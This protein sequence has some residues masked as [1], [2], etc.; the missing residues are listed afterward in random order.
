MARSNGVCHHVWWFVLDS[1]APHGGRRKLTLKSCPMTSIL[2]TQEAEAGES[3]QVWSHVGLYNR[4][5]IKKKIKM[6]FPAVETSPL[7]VESYGLGTALMWHCQLWA[8]TWSNCDAGEG[9]GTGLHK[10]IRW[11]L[12]STTS[13]W[14]RRGDQRRHQH[15]ALSLAMWGPVLT[16]CLS[17]LS[18][19]PWTWAVS[20]NKPLFL[21]NYPASGSSP[22][23]VD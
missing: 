2:S 19:E 20:Q 10:V 17:D 12:R 16:W 18:L 6:E 9:G 21:L 8:D 23:L 14:G 5:L 11:P 1:W 3:L 13:A 15:L 4:T 7:Q 22:V